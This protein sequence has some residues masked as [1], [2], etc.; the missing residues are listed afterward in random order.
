MSEGNSVQR[1]IMMNGL[2]ANL[3]LVPQVRSRDRIQ[4][5]GILT[6]K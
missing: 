6:I 5:I 3:L 2:G 4:M 1:R